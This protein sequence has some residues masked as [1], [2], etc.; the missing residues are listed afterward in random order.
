MMASVPGRVL[1]HIGVVQLFPSVRATRGG[2][3]L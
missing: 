3:R 1:P 2:A